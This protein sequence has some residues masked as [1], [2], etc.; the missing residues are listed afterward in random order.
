MSDQR[1]HTM[2]ASGVPLDQDLVERAARGEVRAFDEIYRRH[3]ATAW[4]VAQAVTRS[5]DDAADAVSEAFTRVFA[6]LSRGPLASGAPFRPYL[7]AATRN[8]AIDI[9]RRSGRVRPAE[10]LETWGPPTTS[11][12]WA[13]GPS[14]R[15]LASED[16][17]LVAAAFRGLPERWRSVLWLTEVEGIPPR[18]AAGML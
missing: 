5:P 3:S 9:L 6:S 17:S 10:D 18:E 2:D 13:P 12:P 15:L 1:T 14:E 11:S 16:A 8:A 7:I 4:R